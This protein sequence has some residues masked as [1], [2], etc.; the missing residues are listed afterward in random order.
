LFRT[1]VPP[2]AAAAN[3]RITEI[4]AFAPAMDFDLS[5]RF[6][7]EIGFT[8]ASE[9]GGVAYFHNCHASFLLQD[10]CGVLWRVAQNVD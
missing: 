5:K 6:Y 3:L 4:K 10:Y 1:E 2:I 8:M 9:V 7:H